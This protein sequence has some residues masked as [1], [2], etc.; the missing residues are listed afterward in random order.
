MSQAELEANVVE[1]I[2]DEIPP[3]LCSFRVMQGNPTRGKSISTFIYHGGPV[4]RQS[5]FAV[6]MH[7]SFPGPSAGTLSVDLCP[8]VVASCSSSRAVIVQDF[9]PGCSL[10]TL[11]GTVTGWKV[12][13]GCKAAP[14]FRLPL[15]GCDSRAVH[16]ALTQLLDHRA[17]FGSDTFQDVDII[18]TPWAQLLRN[19]YLHIVD[20]SEPPAGSDAVALTTS[21]VQLSQ[22]GKTSLST[23][24]CF[25]VSQPVFAPRTALPL[26]CCTPFELGMILQERGW[27]W[28]LMPREVKDRQGLA[29]DSN[30][31]VGAWYTLGETILPAYARCPLSCTELRERH[32]LQMI[33]HYRAV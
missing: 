24:A 3:Q 33:P 16:N 5:D 1:D 29:H 19:E 22:L 11:L 15:E 9:H 14:W 25:E 6:T 17:V 28:Q 20:G 10:Q 18:A 2:R 13:P 8:R 26:K 31:A 27:Q 21:K 30:Q 4:L 7:N 12:S 23:G 32:G